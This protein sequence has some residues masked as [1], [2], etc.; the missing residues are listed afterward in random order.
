MGARLGGRP[1]AL[2]LFLL[3]ALGVRL[4]LLSL[5][6]RGLPV[7]LLARLALEKVQQRA[8]VGR[9]EAVGV[10][11]EEFAQR[12]R[13]RV[14]ADARPDGLIGLGLVEIVFRDHRDRQFGDCR[15][16]VAA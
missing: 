10:A 5:A 12:A 8:R 2:G 15:P 4:P 11:I 14:R 3:Q 9:I 16:F 1:L 13:V 7:R 6:S